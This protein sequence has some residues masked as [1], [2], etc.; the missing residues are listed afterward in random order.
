MP[1]QDERFRIILEY[2]GLGAA[3][4]FEQDMQR[5]QRAADQAGAST[6][7]AAD[8]MGQAHQKTAKAA[9]DAGDTIQEKLYTPLDEI[10]E[11]IVAKNVRALDSFNMAT[12]N[13]GMGAYYANV[14][15]LGMVAN[16]ANI[17]NGLGMM[18]EGVQQ[19]LGDLPLWVAGLTAGA[20]AIGALGAGLVAAA[21]AAGEM[22]RQ[23]RTYQELAP[24]GGIGSAYGTEALAN[25][26]GGNVSGLL[27]TGAGMPVQ[28]MAVEMAFG[29]RPGT[30][31]PLLSGP[32]RYGVSSF[33]PGATIAN[34]VELDANQKI[35]AVSRSVMAQP[36]AR[37]GDALK[38]LAQ[39]YGLQPDDVRKV[40]DIIRQNQ[41][42][43]NDQ[44][45]A[46]IQQQ[47]GGFEPT[48]GQ[49][50]GQSRIEQ[51]QGQINARF[52][53]VVGGLGAGTQG[54]QITGLSGI[55]NILGGQNL[56]GAAVG[57]GLGSFL[58]LGPLL[59]AAFGAADSSGGGAGAPRRS[60]LDL[61][62]IGPLGAGIGVAGGL[63]AGLFGGGGTPGGGAGGPFGGL[64][65]GGGGPGGAP[66]PITLPEIKMPNLPNI[67]LASTLFNE[68][69][70]RLLSILGHIN[71]LNTLFGAFNT[72]LNFLRPIFQPI[73]SGF[74]SV[75]D[76]L[77]AINFDGWRQTIITWGTG[78][79]GAFAS[80]TG[81]IGNFLQQVAGLPASVSVTVSAAWN[82][83]TGAASDAW[84]WLV[85]AGK[86]I[87]N[88]VTATINAVLTGLTGAL[89]SIVGWMTGTAV[90]SIAAKFNATL[91]GLTGTVQTVYNWLTGTA[92]PSIAAT[93]NASLSGLA[94][95]LLTIYHWLTGTAVPG[96][97]T[98]FNVSVSGVVGD[99]LTVY[100][101]LAGKVAVPSLSTF[102]TFLPPNF[103]GAALKMW[104]LLTN[105]NIAANIGVYIS[106][107][108]DSVMQAVA[109]VFG[110]VGQTVSFVFSATIGQALS[111]FI[112]AFQ[113]ITTWVGQTV[114]TNFFG[115]VDG[116][117]NSFVSML[118]GIA[119]WFSKSI[120]LSFGVNFS[121]AVD[122][123]R[124]VANTLF[125]ANLPNAI[126]AN[127]PNIQV[128]Y[129]NDTLSVAGH[130]VLSGF[131]LPNWYHG[132]TMQSVPAGAS[133]SGGSGTVNHFNITVSGLDF[134]DP[135]QIEQI[136]TTV[137]N[138]I[139]KNLATVTGT[140]R[141]L[142]G[143]ARNLP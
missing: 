52:G 104:N 10:A 112:G 125:G 116:T 102:M 122:L 28:Q 129:Q 109:G 12:Y 44:I 40:I 141:V 34:P 82:W 27:A 63:L 139:A 86:G 136:T 117:L 78:A 80:V 140:G 41:G 73:A 110:W 120:N 2:A 48:A 123:L 111:N 134:S 88:S 75:L 51:L 105:P 60:L 22:I 97:A 67:S 72:T 81:S 98:V 118:S 101:W 130:N 90:P 74:Q 14:P 15:M 53:R 84:N 57:L 135:R 68:L 58:G 93:F 33:A 107:T 5:V 142:P 16:V 30:F 108:W 127:L 42:A 128:G 133:S 87:G 137:S 35:I 24:L 3:A 100:N 99:V 25:L 64:F 31:N 79:A 106:G 6:G 56:G 95:D 124:W 66:P 59:G 126:V 7:R 94:G 62:G 83:L 23:V 20:V 37:Q 132:L 119:Q 18:G 39:V 65:G 50:A 77:V 115:T 1:S 26:T 47:Y 54:L 46:I 29:Q 71:P 138:K 143:F 92:V 91:S 32:E 103:S 36:L 131:P 13:L 8:Q 49:V 4:T 89:A 11:P 114:N 85:G 55:S 96:L 113:S 43:S 45:A 17:G 9:A 21:N 76:A 121:G 38:Y 19:M 61:L 69:D 70:V